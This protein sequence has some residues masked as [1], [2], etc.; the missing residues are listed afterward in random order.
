MFHFTPSTL[1]PGFAASR[2]NTYRQQITIPAGA[3]T[4]QSVAR[5]IQTRLALLAKSQKIKQVEVKIKD[6]NEVIV[7]VAAKNRELLQQVTSVL[8]NFK[9]ILSKRGLN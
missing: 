6:G 1:S 5:E 7:N 4:S 8:N 9:S 3:Q 2:T